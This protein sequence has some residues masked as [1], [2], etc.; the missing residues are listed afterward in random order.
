MYGAC[1][2]FAKNWSFTYNT[3]TDGQRIAVGA[4]IGQIFAVLVLGQGDVFIHRGAQVVV[5]VLDVQ[6]LVGGLAG[7]HDGE[8]MRVGIEGS[9]AGGGGKAHVVYNY[10]AAHGLG[11][12]ALA[13]CFHQGIELLVGHSHGLDGGFRSLTTVAVAAGGA[14]NIY[15]GGVF[16]LFHIYLLEI[17]SS[18]NFL[19]SLY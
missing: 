12:S 11:V 16:R 3:L 15:G 9:G 13:G 19:N 6:A 7:H 1:R 5:V 2:Y 17:N 4:E 8:H 14:V 10:D 18:Y